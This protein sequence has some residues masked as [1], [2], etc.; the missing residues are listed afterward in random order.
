MTDSSH[1]NCEAAGHASS[2]QPQDPGPIWDEYKY[3]HDLCW[4][5]VF[6]LTTAVVVISVIPYIQKDV[7]ATLQG[8]IGALPVIGIFLVLLGLARLRG[9]IELLDKVK[10]KH[11]ELLCRNYGLRYPPTAEGFSRHFRGFK[12]HVTWYLVS[13]ALL[14]VANVGVIWF[15]WLPSLS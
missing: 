8:W 1:R 15:E 3:R 9:E 11:R 7:A 6:Q 13:L 4:R 2:S 14:G 5:L 10:T 12:N